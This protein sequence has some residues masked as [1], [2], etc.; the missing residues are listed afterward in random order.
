MF[1]KNYYLNWTAGRANILLKFTYFCNF[2]RDF[3]GVFLFPKT[4]ASCCKKNWNNLCCTVLLF[5]WAQKICLR[6][7]KSY[8]KLEML[9]LLTFVVSFE[10]DMLKLKSYF[11]DKKTSSVKSDTNV[12]REAIGNYRGKILK[13][14]SIIDRSWSP[15]K[16]LIDIFSFFE[17]KVRTCSFQ[18][19]SL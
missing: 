11:S 1:V 4:P 14:P 16:L 9:I 2:G 7:L 12:S 19:L 5:A 8:F 17:F 10:V 3:Y 15:A 13:K 6:F 18:S